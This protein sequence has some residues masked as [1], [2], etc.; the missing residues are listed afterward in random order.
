MNNYLHT[1]IVNFVEEKIMKNKLREGDKLPSE[2]MLAAQFQVSRNV[3]REGINILREK[4]LVTVH[5]GRGAFITKP[6]PLMITSTI[7]RI[8]QNYDT[9]I[10]DVLEAREEL[11]LSIIGKA[12]KA[13]N[14]NDIKEL[15]K[16]YKSMEKYKEDVNLFVKYDIQFHD[17]LAKSTGNTLFSILLNSFIEMTNEVLFTLT[18]MT[19][20]TMEI[21]Q[22]QHLQLIE[23]IEQKD[24]Q[25]GEEFMKAHMH[26]I[27]N[28]IALLK[29][30]NLI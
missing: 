18:K 14:S 27:R 26:V 11:E 1:D 4:G 15:Y 22:K 10:E 6:D 9:T 28:D 30:L 29:E 20:E 23:A 2:R 24:V 13:A 3:V 17:T 16:L 21:A 5:P 19:P 25:K 8:M 12:I 7:E